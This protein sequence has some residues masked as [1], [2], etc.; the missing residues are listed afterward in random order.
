MSKTITIDWQKI[1][2]NLRHAGCT[3]KLIYTKAKMDESTVRR[4]ARGELKEPRF[5]QGLELLDLHERFCPEK[6]KLEELKP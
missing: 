3:T 2:L 4:F 5:S 6:H 1:I